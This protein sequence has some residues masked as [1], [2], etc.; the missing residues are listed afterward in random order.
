MASFHKVTRSWAE[1]SSCCVALVIRHQDALLDRS[2]HQTLPAQK[3]RNQSYQYP[4]LPNQTEE[5]QADK[6]SRISLA[7]VRKQQA[8]AAERQQNPD[9]QLDG[10]A[11]L[12]GAQPSRNSMN[13]AS[14]V[15][16]P[17]TPA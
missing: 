3:K 13:S 14:N 1:V 7:R 9:R 6:D 15:A 11:L 12:Q 16:T 4:S 5:K 8:I 10:L 17:F 2:R